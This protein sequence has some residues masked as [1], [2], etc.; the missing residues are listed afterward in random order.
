M[1]RIVPTYPPLPPRITPIQ[2]A[3]GLPVVLVSVS[4]TYFV[5]YGGL[6]GLWNFLPIDRYDPVVVATGPDTQI[7]IDPNDRRYV[8]PGCNPPTAPLNVLGYPAQLMNRP[9]FNSIELATTGDIR[10]APSGPEHYQLWRSFD[11]TPRR[12]FFENSPGRGCT[13]IE[14]NGTPEIQVERSWLKI[15]VVEYHWLITPLHP[16]PTPVSFYWMPESQ[17]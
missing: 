4:I 6:G 16:I 13:H 10:Y 15:E 12:M 14:M 5:F 9:C 8:N 17:C 11:T 7:T 1:N 2:W 3:I